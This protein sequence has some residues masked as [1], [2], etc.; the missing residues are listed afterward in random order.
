MSHPRD[1]RPTPGVELTD[2]VDGGAPEHSDDERFRA[3]QR[4]GMGGSG[5]V[6][7]EWDGLMERYVALKRLDAKLSTDPRSVRRFV[8]EARI[9][10]KLDHPHIVPIYDLGEDEDG[11]CWL[12]MKL[13]QGRTL[14]QI[15]SDQGVARLEP[16]ALAAH[17]RTLAAVCDALAF[18]HHNGVLHLDVKPANI[19]VNDFGQ[20]YLM[21]WGVARPA[22]AVARAGN[23][24]GGTPA[25]LPPEQAVGEA[26]DARTDVFA[27]GACLYWVLTGNAP[28]TGDTHT[29]LARAA[30]GRFDPP[31]DVLSGLPPGLCAICTRAMHTSPGDR[32][33]DTTVLRDALYAFLQGQWYLDEV[34]FAAGE[35][36]V[37]EGGPGDCAYILTSGTCTVFTMADGER[38]V[39]R[40]LGPGDVFGE[41]AVFT[42]KPRSASVEAAERVT[43]RRVT[44]DT[45]E[46]ELGRNRWLGAFVH[47]VAERFLEA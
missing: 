17:V 5:A 45:L 29:A 34:A 19:M 37:R 36:V 24:V 21:D 40:E 14:R 13:V 38:R 32:Y 33:P 41:T 26:L 39:L 2:T 18:A 42:G 44:R 16:D 12:R 23:P 25:F 22:D 11:G 28:Y 20:V 27:V 46:Q 4:V 47:A 31:R 10:G 43:V 6:Y 15:V 1:E 8:D 30:L 3:L 7:K 9:N 35:L